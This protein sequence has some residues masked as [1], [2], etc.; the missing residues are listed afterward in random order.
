MLFVFE[1]PV[2]SR[3]PLRCI[4]PTL[5]RQLDFAKLII[6]E[7]SVSSVPALRPVVKRT[8]GREIC[9]EVRDR[10]R[11]ARRALNQGHLLPV[12]NRLLFNSHGGLRF[13]K[14]NLSSQIEFAIEFTPP[15]GGLNRVR[16]V[17]S[18]DLL[19]GYVPDL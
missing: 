8:T 15:S 13:R 16:E 10:R 2:K 7:N 14:M 4:K 11:P 9:P 12:A 19:V 3:V 1:R 18:V 17:V 6:L 5:R